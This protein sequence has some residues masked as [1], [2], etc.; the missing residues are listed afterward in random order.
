MPKK[1][2]YGSKAKPKAKSK[3]RNGNTIV[4]KGKRVTSPRKPTR[5]KI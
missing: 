2:G 4:A 3:A 1:T 5:K